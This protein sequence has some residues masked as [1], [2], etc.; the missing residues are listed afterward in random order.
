MT[1]FDYVVHLDSGI[2]DEV[3]EDREQMRAIVG[4]FMIER[5]E[6]A[7]ALRAW[8][9]VKGNAADIGLSVRADNPLQ[10]MCKVTDILRAF[11]RE[12]ESPV[13]EAVYQAE[14]H[15]SR[16]NGRMLAPA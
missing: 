14:P 12:S 4:A 6:A 2:Y 3:P 16:P 11:A 10:A 15:L 9:S 1:E 8:V 5:L 13:R 7:G